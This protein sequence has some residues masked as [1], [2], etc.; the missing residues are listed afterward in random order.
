MKTGFK[1]FLSVLTAA[2]MLCCCL[3]LSSLAAS[4]TIVIRFSAYDGEVIMPAQGI[5]VSEGTAEAYGYD[6]SETDFK[7]DTIEGVTALDA[8]VAAHA[9]YYGSEFSAENA[10]NYLIVSDGMVLKAFGKSA[11]SSGFTVNNKCPN[12]GVIGSWGTYTGYAIDE[13]RLEN[14]DT[15][16]YFFYQDKSFYSDYVGWFTMDG[17]AV[18]TVAVTQAESITLTLEGYSFM[19]YGCSADLE[20]NITPLAGA[21]VYVLSDEGYTSAGKTDENGSITIT[22]DKAGDYRVCAYGETEDAYGITS[23]VSA[24]WCAVSVSTKLQA[25]WNR[26]LDFFARIIEF[27]KNLFSF[28]K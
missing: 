28:N 27:I 11:A 25:F 19:W 17:E 16:S 14:G 5:S 10:N 18:N 8:L 20:E 15:M 3:P 6:V 13:T 7:G 21:D 24:S 2:V 26:I 9:Y 23:P 22:F 4:G 12:D 1:K